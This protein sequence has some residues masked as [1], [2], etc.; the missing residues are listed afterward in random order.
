MRRLVVGLL[1]FV[2]LIVA[3][4]REKDKPIAERGG[5]LTIGTMDLPARISPLQPSVFSSNEVLDLLFLPLHRV[6]AITGKMRPLLAESWEFSEDLKSITYYLRKNVTW[7]DGAP[8]TADDV[9]Y[10]YQKM[11]EPTTNYPY[12]NS[13][14]F[15]KEVRVLGP[16]AIEFTCER[17]Y[18]DILT[19]TDIIPVP[20]H[21][22]EEEGADFALAPVGNGPYR[23]E[24]WVPGQAIVLTVNEHY[25][26]DAPPLESIQLKA[27][28]DA[29][30]MFD[31]FADGDLDLI[32]DIAPNAAQDL[33]KNENVSVLSQPGN[34]YLYVGWNLS[35]PL[36]KETKVREAL[37]MAIN[38]Q[39]ILDNIYL[40]MGKISSGPLTPS[41]WGYNAELSPVS[42]D[43]DRARELLQA[44]GFRYSNRNR[45]LD[46]DGREFSLRLV[47]NSENPDRVAILRYIAED[48]RQIGIRVTTQTLG[49][50]AFI[51]A[52]LQQ[53]F[54]GFIM[55]WSVGDKIDPAVFWSSRGRYNLI[56]YNNPIVDS[57]IE[58][59]VSLLNRKK[60][61]EVWGEFQRIVHEDQPYAFLIVPDRIAATYKR[62]KGIDHEVRLANAQMYWIPEAER[63]VGVAAVISPGREVHQAE[64][65]ISITAR[66][67]TA[68]TVAEE[69]L[70]V[71]APERILEAAAQS[72]T[73]VTD[74]TTAIVANLPPA[75]PKP[76]VI[77]RAEPT[78]RVEPKYPAAAAEF[79]AAGTIVVRVLVGED[80]KVR[81]TRV[82]KSFGNPACEQAALDAARKWEFSPATKD[83]M[84]FEQRVSIPFTF[85]P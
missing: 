79:E 9:L 14:R 42:Y 43:I 31:D 41:S 12:I 6:D 74:S 15:I 60:A 20:K 62:V 77:T 33:A 38:K 56:S 57:L 48:I 10:T 46:K 52:L 82:I 2:L 8:V 39:R 51:D 55:G 59:G 70:S 35:N 61:Q 26:R 50:S 45:L 16:Y 78:K 75:P 34:T 83:G 4:S 25:F 27:Y 73:M 19:D 44:Q 71:V 30:E 22:Y 68:T 28:A 72:D 11:R 66:I 47:T 40:G 18:A 65:A 21:L 24:E 3:C 37:S 49:A 29:D 36:L 85:T 81:E 1:I 63:R 54:D 58:V 17:V 13:L 69:P 67:D 7:S 5:A 80:G 23:I 53:E 32:L 76:S 64:N 84:P